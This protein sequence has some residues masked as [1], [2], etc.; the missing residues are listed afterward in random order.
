MIDW[1][2]AL[3]DAKD[4]KERNN[5]AQVETKDDQYGTP[6][7]VSLTHTSSSVTEMFD[8]HKPNKDF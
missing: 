8:R 1:V 3:K 7:M 5:N 4:K 2:I 6:L